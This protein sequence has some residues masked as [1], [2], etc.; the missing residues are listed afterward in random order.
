IGNLQLLE[1]LPSLESF[2]PFTFPVTLPVSPSQ[3]LVYDVFTT[4]GTAVAGTNYVPIKAGDQMPP[5][6][7]GTVT[8][9]KGVVKQT[10]T[11]WVIPGPLP[12]LAGTKP[13]HVNLSDPAHPTVALATNTGTI[14]PQDAQIAV[15]MP[16]GA[17]GGVTLTAASQ[18]A[19]VIAAAEARWVQAGANPA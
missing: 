11:V 10:V 14:I 6:D 3:T 9:A 15:G 16:T 7:I 12:V 13:F 4:D 1:G 5:H 18:M 2:T 17:P 8:F 19:P